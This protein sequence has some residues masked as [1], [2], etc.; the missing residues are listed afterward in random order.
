MRKKPILV[1]LAFIVTGLIPALASPAQD[2]FDQA[3]FYLGFYYSGPGKIAP[4]RELRK[5][6]QPELDKLCA[7]DAKCGY[8]KALTVI[9]Q[10]IASL[11]DP[12]VQIIN[13]DFERLAGGQGPARPRLGIVTRAHNGG[14]LVARTMEGE[15]A[16]EAGVERGDVIKTVNGKPATLEALVTA[17]LANQPITLGLERKGQAQNLNPIKPAIA[18]EGQ[19]PTALRNTPKNVMVIKV[20][21][22]YWDGEVAKRVHQLVRRANNDGTKNIVVDLRDSD[23]GFDSEAIWTARA[24]TEQITLKYQSRFAGSLRTF[25]VNG[26]RIAGTRDGVQGTATLGQLEK[27][28]IFKGGVAVLVNKFTAHTGEMVAYLMQQNAKARVIG[29]PTAGQLGVSGGLPSLDVSIGDTELINGQYINLS[30][31]KIL[32]ASGKPWPM[33]V[34]P[35]I[36]V[37]DDLAA[38]ATGRDPVLEKAYELLGVK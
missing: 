28:Q 18:E 15:P 8:D 2:L 4:F 5:Q 6:Y 13:S 3:T 21:D 36:A 25:T 22:F 9:N 26:E 14:L 17:E 33:Q 19:K 32:D 1:T 12:Y 31:D 10:I 30:N 29:E 11:N 27:P 38:I 35:D 24:F 23:T 34:T 7:G 20:P 37:P 16:W